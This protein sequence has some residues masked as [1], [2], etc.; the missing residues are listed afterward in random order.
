MAAVQDDKLFRE[1]LLAKV[2]PDGTL[3][4]EAT[5]RL[6]A[7]MATLYPEDDE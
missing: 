5:R 6:N 4:K 2:E 1:V 3:P 7:W